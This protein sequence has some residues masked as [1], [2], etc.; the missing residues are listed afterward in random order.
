M[1]HIDFKPENLTGE[2]KE[3]WDK[4]NEDSTRMMN[5][6][7]AKWSNNEE[8]IFDSKHWG[9]LKDWLLE[10]VFNGK[11]AYCETIMDRAVYQAEHYRPKGK[12]TV[13]DPV[14]QKEIKVKVQI[15]GKEE[16]HPGYFW[17][18]LNWRNLLPSCEKCNTYGGKGTKFPT[19]REH[20]YLLQ[21]K[22]IKENEL[23]PGYIKANKDGNEYY[24][25]SVNDL[26]RLED[27]NLLHPYFHEPK[28]FLIFGSKGTI[29]SINNNAKGEDSIKTYNLRDE[30]LRI[31]RQ[32]AQES[33]THVY[34]EYIEACLI[35][36]ETAKE[37]VKKEKAEELESYK[38]GKAEYS[39]AA[40]S[41]LE[42]QL[43]D[44]NL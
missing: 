21:T 40:L 26:N 13:L 10:N 8:Y 32:E 29:A 17:L 15:N 25:L 28:D 3:W 22:D 9:K 31:G 30:K 11:C 19:T 24:L 6:I 35:K 20:I 41:F 33:A 42:D 43:K 16:D 12:V 14:T 4:W 44:I 5:D 36:D 38:C 37:L 39:A 34:V 23:Y 7:I 27:P 1:I 2:Q 18:A